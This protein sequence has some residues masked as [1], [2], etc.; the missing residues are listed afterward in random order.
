[1][2]HLAL[3][4]PPMTGPGETSGATSFEALELMAADIAGSLLGSREP[5]S[6]D[7]PPWGLDAGSDA[8]AYRQ[9]QAQGGTALP[10]GSDHVDD[11]LHMDHTVEGPTFVVVPRLE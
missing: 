4:A 11:T 2:L 3:P 10:V 6:A 7:R 8:V 1:M 5:P 9:W